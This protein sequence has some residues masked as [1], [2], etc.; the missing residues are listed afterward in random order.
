MQRVISRFE[1]ELD[2]ASPSDL[3]SEPDAKEALEKL[4]EL[5]FVQ[6]VHGSGTNDRGNGSD[7]EVDFRLFAGP[8]PTTA[9]NEVTGPQ[10]IR[11][12]SP[13][14]DISNPGFIRAARDLSYYFANTLSLSDKENLAA[15]A[16]SGPQIIELSKSY[17]P[18]SA[19]NWKVLRLSASNLSKS[20]RDSNISAFRKLVDDHE[21]RKRKR[22]GKKARVKVRIKQEQLEEQRLTRQ[23]TVEAKE[24]AEREKRT[25]RN[26]EKKVKKKMRDKA[27]KVESTDKAMSP[28]SNE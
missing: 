11:L 7:E 8:K 21:P 18:G 13:S 23:A 25:K 12:R 27:K 4:D 1:L 14:V 9:K 28:P 6:A 17:R 24:A 20:L 19:Y 10:K 15:S 3:G 22:P 16:L 2:R 26:R 5:E